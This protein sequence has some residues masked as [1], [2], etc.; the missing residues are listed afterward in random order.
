MRLRKGQWYRR[1]GA[2]LT[3]IAVLALAACGS[4]GALSQDGDSGLVH[5][6]DRLDTAMVT[7]GGPPAAAHQKRNWEFPGAQSEWR[8]LA[9]PELP[10]LAAVAVAPIADGLRLSL[11][12]PASRQTM[13]YLG[14][15]ATDLEGLR[16]GDW[17]A[18]L[19]KARSSDRFAGLAVAHNVSDRS[20]LP[21][22]ME[23][24]FTTGDVPP[25]FSDG[26]EQTYML[27]IRLRD[28]ESA[29]TELES[30]AIVFGA[31]GAAS[32]DVLSVSMVPRGAAFLE[33]YGV[34]SVTRGGFTVDTLFA[35]TPA[36]VV[37][38]IDLREGARLD[39]RLSAGSGTSVT[40]RISVNASGESRQL[41]EQTIDG[42]GLG[43]DHSIDLSQLAG[44]G[45]EIAL[46]A[47]SDR[48]GSLA[49]WGMPMV[50][51]AR[52]SDRPNVILYIIDGGG[53]DLMSVYGYSRPT[54]PYLEEL[55]KEGAIFER[56]YS[57]STWTQPSTVSFLTS[58]HHS[59]L[60]GLRRGVH[61][62]P[63]PAAATTMAE[64][65]RRGG[66]QTMSFTGNPNAGRL[67]GTERGVDLMWDEGVEHHS[68]SSVSL[69]DEFWN[70][71][72]AF[73]GTPYWV[74]FQTTDVHEPNQPEPPFAGQYV[75]PEE[76]TQLH[77]WD[78]QVFKAAGAS[79]GRTSV[80]GFY[81][82]ALEQTG[83]DRQAYFGIRRGLYDET[84]THQDYQLQ[85]L[86]ERLKAEGEWE[87]TLLVI[88]ADHGHPAGTFARFGRG[89]FEPQPDPWEGALFDAYA[90]RVPLIMVWPG[91]I[92]AG[93]Q[94]ERAVSMIDVLPT[95]LDLVGLPEPEVLQGQSLAPLLRGESMRVRP[96]IL[97]E[98]RVHEESGEML[99]N[100]E[101]I[102][103]R[104]GASLEIGPAPDGSDSDRGRHEV[105][106]GGRW[107]A[108]HRYFPDVPRLLLYD[109]STD[110]FALKAVNDEHPAEVERYRR[111]L[112]E[113]WKAH[114]ALAQRFGDADEVPLDPEQLQQLKSLGYIQ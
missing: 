88:G 54:T 100:L 103:G 58:L 27:P 31:P 65:M 61:S 62:T 23:F 37:Y 47:T 75:T 78:Q 89:L 29:D 11:S 41:F 55:A 12:Q 46:E 57:N 95:I 21:N 33:D 20:A 104:W 35:H 74:H 72:Q 84:M 91:G 110:P 107:G 49:M 113:Q 79:F 22:D 24:F 48:E 45:R 51:A 13:L 76:Q 66:Y 101:I 82:L 53:A 106:V 7:S 56:A 86:V 9:S 97:D 26:S 1:G 36:K 105:P 14:G 50:S 5:L 99:G 52:L 93:L 60:G 77:Q 96:V 63:V 73:P 80:T 19:V 111:I 18:V 43:T 114:Q 98:F 32:V 112:L 92:E 42:A 71:R 67:I 8:T 108:V 70:H 94:F 90:T 40:Y 16:L 102:D 38:P 25:V 4:E 68:T 15:I 39:F 10:R 6:T 87:N 28:G 109:L 3:V 83:I 64:Y 44:S 59:V 2:V 69:H 34:R 85:Q 17:E 30:V 81:D